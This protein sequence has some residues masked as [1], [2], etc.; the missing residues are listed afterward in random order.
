ML[1]RLREFGVRLFQV[2]QSSRFFELF[3]G[4]FFG[5]KHLGVCLVQFALTTATTFLMSTIQLTDFLNSKFNSKTIL[6]VGN[7]KIIPYTKFEHTAIIRYGVMLR[8][9]VWKMHVLTLIPR[10]FNHKMIPFVG[11]PEVIPHTK[12]EFCDLSFL[13]H[14]ADKQRDGLEGPTHAN[15]RWPQESAWVMTIFFWSYSWQGWVCCSCN[16]LIVCWGIAA[17]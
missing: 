14:A 16:Y 9:I 2:R 13:S 5:G 15:S 1:Q 17:S 7:H 10:P 4:S 12:F 3:L 8:T 11:Y 6:L